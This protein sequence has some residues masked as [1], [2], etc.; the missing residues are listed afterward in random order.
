MKSLPNTSA[1][2][3]SFPNCS[4]GHKLE[5]ATSLSPNVK[6]RGPEHKQVLPCSDQP[7]IP[8]NTNIDNSSNTPKIVDSTRPKRTLRIPD[9]LNYSKLGGNN[10]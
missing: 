10:T 8:S 3:K 5:K 1:G 2:D 9:R 4:S 7:V 6:F